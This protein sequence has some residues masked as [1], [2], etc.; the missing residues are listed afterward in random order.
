VERSYTRKYGYW[1]IMHFIALRQDVV[2]RYPWAA[3]AFYDA[4]VQAKAKALWHWEDPNWSLLA[5]GRHYLEDEQE[6][7][8]GDAWPYG[9]A[10]NRINL[11]RF[12][13]YSQEQGLIRAPLPLEKLFHESVL[14]T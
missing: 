10:R 11:E 14:D 7:F 4:F 5:W 13:G 12:M 8:G 1:P 3:R 6:Q 9:V 2:E